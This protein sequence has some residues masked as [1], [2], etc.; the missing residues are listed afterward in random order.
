VG[1]DTIMGRLFMGDT[2]D[3]IIKGRP[4]NSVIISP[5]ADFAWWR[6]F[7]VTPAFYV[8]L[9][10]TYLPVTAVYVVVAVVVES[11]SNCDMQYLPP[12]RPPTSLGYI[13]SR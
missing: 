3:I 2:G 10:T 13:Y 4:I 7:N 9:Y 6:H 5:R 12:A 1:R 11:C 8:F